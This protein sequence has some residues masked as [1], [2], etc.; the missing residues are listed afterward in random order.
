MSHVCDG[1]GIGYA[2][3]IGA[4]SVLLSTMSDRGRR[5]RSLRPALQ[6]HMAGL[7]ASGAVTRL[8]KHAEMT[9]AEP[10]RAARTM[11]SINT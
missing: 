7:H 5:A 10:G 11:A 9:H 6:P 2:Y 4:K 3:G 1:R 8:A